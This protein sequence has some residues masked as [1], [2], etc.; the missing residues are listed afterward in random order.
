MPPSAADFAAE[1]VQSHQ[2]GRNGMVL[3]VAI[4]DPA[5]PLALH[6]HGFVPP[7]EEL[8]ADRGQRVSHT[9]LDGYTNH[10]ELSL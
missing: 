5:K 9:F 6:R 1:A 4:Q 2:V 3:E 7:L 8:F 10:L